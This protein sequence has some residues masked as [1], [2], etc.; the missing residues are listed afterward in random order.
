MSQGL[1]I[2]NL[3]CFVDLIDLN[4]DTEEDISNQT[5]ES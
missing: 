2:I 4:D 3:G 5:S 1:K